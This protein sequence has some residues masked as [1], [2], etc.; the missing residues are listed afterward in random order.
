MSKE[1]KFSWNKKD[2]E[3]HHRWIGKELERIV[4]EGEG[5]TPPKTRLAKAKKQK[6]SN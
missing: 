5:E 1:R 6:E 2:R 3:R 4:A